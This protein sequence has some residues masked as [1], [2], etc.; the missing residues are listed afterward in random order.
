MSCL[1]QLAW[2]RENMLVGFQYLILPPAPRN[3]CTERWLSV[4]ALP[5]DS[6]P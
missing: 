4:A 1:G 6:T 2:V 5:P 3:P